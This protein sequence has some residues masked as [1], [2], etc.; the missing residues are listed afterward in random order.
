MPTSRMILNAA[1]PDKTSLGTVNG[2]AQSVAAAATI[3]GPLITGWTY[4]VGL[5]QGI[6]GIA[7]W[8]MSGFAILN[9][10]AGAALMYESRHGEKCKPSIQGEL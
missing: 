6:V 1:S 5:R 2:I 3:V 4:G 8:T 7:W 10:V 9:A